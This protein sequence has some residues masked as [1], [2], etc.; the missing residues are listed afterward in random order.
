MTGF[1][2]LEGL[3]GKDLR[4]GIIPWS[5]PMVLEAAKCGFESWLRC[6]LQWNVG[7]ITFLL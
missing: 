6:F 5:S 4:D 7:Q 3:K 2:A 1:L